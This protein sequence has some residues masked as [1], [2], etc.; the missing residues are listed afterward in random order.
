MHL[1]ILKSILFHPAVISLS[2]CA[3]LKRRF[4]IWISV[5][6]CCAVQKVSIV[7]QKLEICFLTK[8]PSKI[9]LK[10]LINKVILGIMYY[11]F[12]GNH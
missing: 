9:L 12:S 10:S 4:N 11:S 8:F 3:S 5:I 2:L 1:R 6:F 7:I